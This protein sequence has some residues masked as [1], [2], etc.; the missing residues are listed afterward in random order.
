MDRECRHFSL[1]RLIR[2]EKIARVMLADPFH[3]RPANSPQHKLKILFMN[4]KDTSLPVQKSKINAVTTTERVE[5]I[6]PF[7]CYE[8]RYDETGIQGRI[9][10]PVST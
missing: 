10:R 8:G 3:T 6:N 1:S 2:G 4:E 7:Y 9:Q 5:D